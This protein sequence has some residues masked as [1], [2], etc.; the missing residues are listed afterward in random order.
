MA[1]IN[2]KMTLSI[3][4]RRKHKR[5]MLENIHSESPIECYGDLTNYDTVLRD[6]K[7]GINAYVSRLM[8]SIIGQG[9]SPFHHTYILEMINYDLESL[10]I[11]E[12]GSDADILYN[13]PIGW[14]YVLHPRQLPVS[15]T[16]DGGQ[17]KKTSTDVII[18]ALLFFRILCYWKYI[19]HSKYN[20]VPLLISSRGDKDPVVGDYIQKILDNVDY[21]QY[22]ACLSQKLQI[23]VG[24]QTILYTIGDWQWKFFFIDGSVGPA[25]TYRIAGLAKWHYGTCTGVAYNDSELYDALRGT[26]IYR[27]DKSYRDSLY[28]YDSTYYKLVDIELAHKWTKEI[29]DIIEEYKENI[30]A[31]LLNDKKFMRL[32][33]IEIAKSKKHG[34][35]YSLRNALYQWTIDVSHGIWSITTHQYVMF[36]ELMWCV[37]NIDYNII[38]IIIEVIPSDY[39]KQ[40][41]KKYCKGNKNRIVRYEW[42][43]HT[44]GLL[45]RK[46]L[47]NFNLML[48]R[49]AYLFNEIEVFESEG[50]ARNRSYI[51]STA[52][53]ALFR[54]IS[55]LRRLFGILLIDFLEKDENGNQ[56]PFIDE[57]ID[58]ARLSTYLIYHLMHS[59]V[60]YLFLYIL[61]YTH[62]H[63]CTKL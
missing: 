18:T 10:P 9:H 57:A 42:K 41:T 46:I 2:L 59:S 51:R 21:F 40:Q 56:H 34:L 28:D 16:G 43:L 23:Y 15:V 63:I 44:T 61:Y 25:G 3:P 33:R 37:W 60:C 58:L 32:I 30:D 38:C 54:I 26:F 24:Y 47:Q 62:T 6:C 8:D 1:G 27:F 22:V 35:L 20:L 45:C 53:M 39:I 4:N 52:T 31:E 17:L 7:Q 5:W 48:G 55:K 29:D 49:A 14:P 11:C 12:A 50:I 19:V 36:I 13:I